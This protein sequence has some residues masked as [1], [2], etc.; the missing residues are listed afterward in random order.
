M[1]TTSPSPITVVEA[2][3]ERYPTWHREWGFGTLDMKPEHS[4][5]AGLLP[6]EHTDPFDRMLVAQSQLH[7]AT[8]VTRDPEIQRVHPNC[9]W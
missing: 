8:L 1:T 5:R 6:M 7:G 3:L 4:V 9:L 2:Y